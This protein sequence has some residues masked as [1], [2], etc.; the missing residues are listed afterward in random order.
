[1]E[2]YAQV[3]LLQDTYWYEFLYSRV[4]SKK[5]YFIDVP[6][7]DR[8]KHYQ[9]LEDQFV[10]AVLETNQRSLETPKLQDEFG[11]ILHYYLPDMPL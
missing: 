4:L 9:E 10:K 3:C 11:L 8:E 6:T 7:G 2:I 1:M 5:G